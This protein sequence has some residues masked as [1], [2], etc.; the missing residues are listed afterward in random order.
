MGL[1]AIV[2][3]AGVTQWLKTGDE[4]EMDGARGCVRRLA[5]GDE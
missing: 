4:V 2:S 5:R 3:V 1:P